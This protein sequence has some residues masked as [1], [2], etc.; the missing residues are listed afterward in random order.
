MTKQPK[1]PTL[2]QLR[3]L[4]KRAGLDIETDVD[5]GNRPKEVELWWE[6]SLVHFATLHADIDNEIVRIALRGMLS[7]LP[8]KRGPR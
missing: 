1:T 7:S 5:R 3:K 4:A 8:D 6:C 2:A